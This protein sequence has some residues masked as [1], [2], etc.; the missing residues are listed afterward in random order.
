MYVMTIREGCSRHSVER[1]LGT[2]ENE[3]NTQEEE[4]DEDD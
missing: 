1:L 2:L 4:T 3:I